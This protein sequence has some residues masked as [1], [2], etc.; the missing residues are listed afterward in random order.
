ML[1]F[2][3]ALYSLSF[4]NGRRSIMQGVA[5]TFEHIPVLKSIEK[6]NSFIDIGAN[7]GQFSLAARHVFQDASIISFEPLKTP[8]NKFKKLFKLDKKANLFQSAI[9]PK[10]EAVQMHVSY[11]DDS[12]SLLNIGENQSSIFPGTKEKSTEEINVAPL[13]YFINNNDLINPVFVKIDVQGYELEVLKGSKSL[14]DEFDYI[15]VECSFVELYEG[16]ALADEVIA[17]LANYSFR[18]KGVYNTFYDKKGIAIQADL[19]FSKR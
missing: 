7:K 13:N 6:I 4:K 5:L 3:K 15:Y 2:K 14:I 17:Y 18:L 1:K 12:S 19:L 10:R 16:Q 9:G 8:A 11:Q